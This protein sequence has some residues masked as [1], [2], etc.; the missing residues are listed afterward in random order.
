MLVSGNYQM[1]PSSTDR[2]AY[3]L[4]QANRKIAATLSKTSRLNIQNR[5][6]IIS[7]HR[8]DQKSEASIF[9]YPYLHNDCTNLHN[10]WYTSR[11]F[12]FKHILN[13]I[14]NKFIIQVAPP[15]DNNNNL[16]FF[17]L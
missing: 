7:Q 16:V 13:S 8:V 5:S 6:D 2:L 11:L 17:H 14:L 3:N 9:D 10:F 4:T 1:C 15:S 12:H